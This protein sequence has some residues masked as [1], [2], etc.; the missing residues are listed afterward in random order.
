MVLLTADKGLAR[1]AAKLNVRHE[2]LT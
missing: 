2:I 1:A